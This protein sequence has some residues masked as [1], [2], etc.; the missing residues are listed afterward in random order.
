[1]RLPVTWTD[2][3][4]GAPA[5]P[6]VLLV[7]GVGVGPTAF[8]PVAERLAGAGHRVGVVHRPGYGLA[9]GHLFTPLATQVAALS[10]LVD[11]LSAGP[12]VVL[13][14]VSGGATLALLAAIARARTPV[15]GGAVTVVCHEP[16]VGPLAPDLHRRVT[17]AVGELALGTGRFVRHL[18]GEATWAQLDANARATTVRR[19]DLVA[20]EARAFARVAPTPG[21]L[22]A[23]RLDGGLVTTVGEHSGPERHRVAAVL[24][25]LSGS[26]VEVVTGAG[27]LAQVDAPDAFV[28]AILAAAP[29]EVLS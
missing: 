20:A 21:D 19:P 5:G 13:V 18:V 10:R 25:R 28:A 23:V 11:S 15:A 16:L 2:P 3:P 6:P 14:G 8:E 17:R 27:H 1:M 22:A 29:A 12:G 24:A 7:H 26:R 4:G 9:A